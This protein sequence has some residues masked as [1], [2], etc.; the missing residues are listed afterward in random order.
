MTD[1]NSNAPDAATTAGIV[2]RA[3]EPADLLTVAALRWQWILENDGE[4]AVSHGEFVEFFTDWAAR[5]DGTHHCTVARRGDTVIGMAWLAVLPRVPSPRALVRASGDVQC[6]Y[7]VPTERDAG[8][9][10]RML[11]TVLR[12]AF[13]LGLERV[14]VHSSPGAITA[15]ARAGFEVSDQLLQAT[16][17]AA[18]QAAPSAT[19]A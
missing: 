6:V 7:V 16:P 9:G 18:P 15:Y 11:D 13:D 4:P 17:S 5:A 19:R 10:A 1:V 3:A 8:V 12:Q 14:T 2:I